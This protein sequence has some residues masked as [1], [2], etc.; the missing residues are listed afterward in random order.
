MASQRGLLLRGRAHKAGVVKRLPVMPLLV[1]PE[2]LWSKAEGPVNC[3]APHDVGYA[4]RVFLDPPVVFI[5]AQGR[6][7]WQTSQERRKYI[8]FF[9]GSVAG[10]LAICQGE[11]GPCYD[12]FV[13]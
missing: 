5:T 11:P 13:T 4:H 8:V 2:P 12:D 1:C 6:D 10:H 7:H 3:Q 9:Y